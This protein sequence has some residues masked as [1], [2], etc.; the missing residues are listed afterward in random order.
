MTDEKP[1]DREIQSVAPSRV[2]GDALDA[3][4]RAVVNVS[5]KVSPSVVRVE[6]SGRG[7]GSGFIVTPDGYLLTNSHVINGA[8]KVRVVLNDGHALL[9]SLVGD[10]PH[11][12]LALLRVDAADITDRPA[13]TLADSA[14]LRVGQLVVA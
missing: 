5:E 9:G 6:V 8:R 3:Y 2:E 12:D 11:T 4:S 13:L 7:V 10:D 1:V 14:T